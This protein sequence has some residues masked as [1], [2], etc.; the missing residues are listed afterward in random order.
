MFFGLT[1]QLRCLGA[2]LALFVMAF[3]PAYQIDATCASQNFS[4]SSAVAVDFLCFLTLSFN[5]ITM[6]VLAI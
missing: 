6:P 5:V 4:L 2:Y 3:F 1:K